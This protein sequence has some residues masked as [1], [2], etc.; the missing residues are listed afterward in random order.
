MKCI[1]IICLIFALSITAYGQQPGTIPTLTMPASRSP[2]PPAGGCNFCSRRYD[3]EQVGNVEQAG[4]VRRQADQ[5]RQALMRRLDVLQAEIDQ[6]R[7]AT[8]AGPQVKVQIQ[9]SSLDHQVAEIGLRLD[10]TLRRFQHK[11][12]D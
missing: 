7:L 8:G 3:L 11:I 6:I 10:E 2:I 5:E 1:P 12:R 4:V 9:V